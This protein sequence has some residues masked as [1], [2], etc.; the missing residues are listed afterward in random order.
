MSGGCSLLAQPAMPVY[1]LSEMGHRP[2]VT[3]LLTVFQRTAFIRAAIASALA[4]TWPAD[5]ILVTD[6]SASAEIRRI[7][8]ESGVRYRANPTPLGVARNV[9]A[10]A[11]E[12]RGDLLTILND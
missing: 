11:A 6:D 3:V 7:C 2:S 12:A 4:Q 10:A 5:E 1:P 9:A 8:E